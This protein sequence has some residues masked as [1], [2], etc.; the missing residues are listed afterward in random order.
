MSPNATRVATALHVPTSF[1][2]EHV[3][4]Q[5][6]VPIAGLA[7][8]IHKLAACKDCLPPA[9]DALCKG[10]GGVRA[11][12]HLLIQVGAAGREYDTL[13]TMAEAASRCCGKPLQVC[14]ACFKPP[15]PACVPMCGTPAACLT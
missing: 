13:C 11:Q 1:L 4:T 14:L 5:R 2:T 10:C 15:R 8:Q 7:P 6:E 9:A 3:R 12:A